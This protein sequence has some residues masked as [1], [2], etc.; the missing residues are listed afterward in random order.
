MDII[1]ENQTDAVLAQLDRGEADAKTQMSVLAALLRSQTQLLECVGSIQKSLWTENNLE[2]IIDRRL[3][4][5]CVTCPAKRFTD[6]R[7]TQA[8]EPVQT[9]KKTVLEMI[10]T[11]ESLR[12]FILVVVLIWAVIYMRT[13]TEGVAAVQDGVTH[14]MTG[15]HK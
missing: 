2:Q 11:S 4:S 3:E 10:F 12:Y 14:T 1:A 6:L 9:P 15:G 8:A 13:G 7:V 5:R